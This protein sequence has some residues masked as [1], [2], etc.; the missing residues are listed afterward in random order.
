MAKGK[1]DKNDAI[2]RAFLTNIEQGVTITKAAELC[3]ISR[4]A[5]YEWLKADAVFAAAFEQAKSKRI[6][7]LEEA[8]FA[9]AAS[10]SVP[11]LIF[12]ACN[13]SPEKYRNTQYVDASIKAGSAINRFTVTEL[14][15]IARGEDPKKVLE[16][17][18]TGHK[19][20]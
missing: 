9:T 7:V 12:L 2:K 19:P 1:P 15:R 18:G 10:G 13:W 20:Q 5:F 6:V 8:M 3:G 4:N 17:R 14:A 11:M 16:S